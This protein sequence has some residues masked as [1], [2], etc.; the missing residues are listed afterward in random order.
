[1]IPLELYTM[2]GGTL[3]GF[4]T[5]FVAMRAQDR[6]EQFKI[7]MSKFQAQESAHNAAI[8]RVS[9]DAGKWVR[10][11]IVIS[12]LFAVILAPFIMALLGYPVIVQ[13]EETQR[14]WLFGLFGGGTKTTF[15]EINGFLL[16]PEVRA[17][18]TSIL[19]LY[20]GSALSKVD[21]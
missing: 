18:L 21:K 2:L 20:M 6:Q 13:L 3:L 1:M 7:L 4:I 15:Y 11:I 8:Q 16:I 19:G 17:A 5:K 14:Q 10:R 12:V 9:V